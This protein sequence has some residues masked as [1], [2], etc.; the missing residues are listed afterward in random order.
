VIA[1][2]SVADRLV[3]DDRVQV[4]TD[5]SASFTKI[6]DDAALRRMEQAGAVITS[7]SQ[8]ISELA[9]DRTT[10]RGQA[11]AKLLGLESLRRVPRKWH[12]PPASTGAGPVHNSTPP[13]RYRDD[14]DA[15]AQSGGTRVRMKCQTSPHA[16]A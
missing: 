10:P 6:G 2:V 8:I 11:L 5:A 15:I 3:A 12:L 13:F 16:A 7:T 4:V 14:S 9:I 1:D